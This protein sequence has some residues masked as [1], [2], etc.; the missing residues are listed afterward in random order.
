MKPE[1]TDR[2]KALCIQPPV[3]DFALYDLY[4]K[5][6]GLLRI[7]RWLED[8]GY[9]VSFVDALDY[10]D[11]LSIGRLGKPKRKA[12]GTGKFFREPVLEPAVFRSVKKKSAG[13][14]RRFARYGILTESFKHR[15]AEKRPDI[16]LVSSGMT[17]WYYGVAET[18]ALCRGIWPNVPI[19]VGGVY[20]SLMREHCLKAT[21][22]DFAVSGDGGAGLAELLPALHLP[23][24]AGMLPSGP[25]PLRSV[26]ADAGVLRLNAGCPFFCDYCASVQVSGRFSR[27][28]PEK[29]FSDFL[30]L[31]S[32]C[33]TRH[34][35]FYDDALLAD[36]ESVFVPFLKRIADGKFDAAFYLPNA[37]HIRFLDEDTARLM[38]RAGFRE[39]RIGFESASPEFHEG[40]DD[41]LTPAM[42]GPAIQALKA[43]GFSGASIGVYVLAGL[44]GQYAEEV[45]ASVQYAGSWGVRVHVAEFSPV[46]GTGLWRQCVASSA[47][48][49]AEE[50]L[51]HNNSFFPMEWEH[52]TAEDLKRLKALSLT[53]VRKS[54]E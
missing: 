41:K 38:K 7:A 53:F 6:F 9:D 21:G 1:R 19:V 46:P 48:P 45:E 39:I 34:F 54:L 43:A 44:P 32:S 33:G 22:A 25:L 42:Y 20:A 14:S 27:G 51:F 16:V 49:L 18:V 26:F 52:F 23:V 37:V 28:D 31:Y 13:F 36:K 50:P 40:H 11:P 30:S 24:P 4:L 29:L 17:Y 2:P 35:A 3:Y 10:R 15:I 47:L 5:P 8:G 12:D